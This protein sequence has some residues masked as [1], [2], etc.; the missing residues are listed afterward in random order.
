MFGVEFLLERF[1]NY[2]WSSSKISQITKND[3]WQFELEKKN[4]DVELIFAKHV[5]IVNHPSNV[6][7]SD[8]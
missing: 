6:I 5:F 2:K 1:S 3:R 7:I 8:S 4:Y